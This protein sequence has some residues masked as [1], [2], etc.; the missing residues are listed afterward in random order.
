MRH[1]NVVHHPPRWQVGVAPQVLTLVVDLCKLTQGFTDT[2]SPADLTLQH[3]HLKRSKVLI[4]SYDSVKPVVLLRV[5]ALHIVLGVH[6]RQTLAPYI[7]I[8]LDGKVL[9]QVRTVGKLQDSNS[10]S[11]LSAFLEH[12]GEGLPLEVP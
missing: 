11:W 5:N 8:L 4:G 7:P 9:R 3:T 6:L 1:A 2:F 12:L 10:R